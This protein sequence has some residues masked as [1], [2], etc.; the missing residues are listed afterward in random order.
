[1]ASMF[2]VPI[3]YRDLARLRKLWIACLRRRGLSSESRIS[4]IAN[5]KALAGRM[6]PGVR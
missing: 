4:S 3:D 5:A 6:P 1:M 2:E